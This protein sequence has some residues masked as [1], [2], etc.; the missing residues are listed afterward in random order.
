M[1]AWPEW[2]KISQSVKWHK[3]THYYTC[4]YSINH[5]NTQFEINSDEHI[6]H[7]MGSADEGMCVQVELSRYSYTTKYL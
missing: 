3:D 2:P 1:Q 5:K 6:W 7:L 4:I